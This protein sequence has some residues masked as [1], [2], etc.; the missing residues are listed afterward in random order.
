M[1][2]WI[3]RGGWVKGIK[4]TRDFGGEGTE[5]SRDSNQAP[6]T[7]FHSAR[8]IQVKTQRDLRIH[9][10]HLK[11]PLFETTERIDLEH[12]IT[13]PSIPARETHSNLQ[14]PVDRARNMKW[15]KIII[16]WIL[17]VFSYLFGARQ[18]L[19][20]PYHLKFKTDE[21]FRSGSWRTQIEERESGRGHHYDACVC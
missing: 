19:N 5:W 15:R 9:I 18:L 10:E 8:S 20:S 2:K 11:A 14:K 17:L 4:R 1:T 3:I 21:W 6:R 12:H 16:I 7:L 13:P